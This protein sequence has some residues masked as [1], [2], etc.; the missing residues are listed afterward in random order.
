MFFS[1]DE[2]WCEVIPIDVGHV[3]LNRT[4]LYNLNVTIFNQSNSWSFN[5]QDKKD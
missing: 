4:W 2:G 1:L 3:I 5:F